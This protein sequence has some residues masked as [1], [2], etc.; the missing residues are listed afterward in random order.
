MSYEIGKTMFSH[1]VERVYV[2]WRQPDDELMMEKNG[3]IW[4]SIPQ[5]EDASGLSPKLD[6]K[7]IETV[8]LVMV[9]GRRM[10]PNSSDS[11]MIKTQVHTLRR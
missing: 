2:C 4:Y 3:R 5:F 7:F 9:L 11:L 1:G 10:A 8:H 6:R